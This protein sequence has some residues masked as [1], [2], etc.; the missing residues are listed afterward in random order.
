LNKAR[1]GFGE[2]G[3]CRPSEQLLCSS[4]TI[5]SRKGLGTGDFAA[6]RIDLRLE[7]HAD[8]LVSNYR[9]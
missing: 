9:R 1:K 3:C 6:G 5:P 8:L 7:N 4:N 2:P